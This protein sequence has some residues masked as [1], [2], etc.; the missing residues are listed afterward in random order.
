MFARI[1]SVEESEATNQGGNYDRE[2]PEQNGNG[3]GDTETSTTDILQGVLVV[4]V[5]AALLVILIRATRER[6]SGGG[7]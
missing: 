2:E 3:N 7:E 6:T 5:V 4:G 1:T